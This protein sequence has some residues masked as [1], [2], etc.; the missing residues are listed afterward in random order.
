MAEHTY[1]VIEVVGTSE[2]GVTEAIANGV[3]RASRT[4]EMLDWFE[5]IEIRGHLDNGVSP[6]TRS[7]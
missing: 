3:A 2:E 5:V 4:V 1:R 7:G 6:I